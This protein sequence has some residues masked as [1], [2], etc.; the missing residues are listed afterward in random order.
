MFRQPWDAWTLQKR[1][2]GLTPM[3]TDNATYYT[4]TYGNYNRYQYPSS[5]QTY[6]QKNWLAE[7]NNSDLV[8]TKIW[9][10]K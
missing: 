5:E 10:A 7:T 4:N 3:E 6:N 9:I 8:S 1:T 2:G